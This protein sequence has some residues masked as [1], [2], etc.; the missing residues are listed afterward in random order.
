MN[1]NVTVL[2]DCLAYFDAEQFGHDDNNIDAETAKLMALDQQRLAHMFGED[3]M[4][5]HSVEQYFD[6]DQFNDASVLL[7]T[8]DTLDLVL[9]V[10]S[11]I[12]CDL[13]WEI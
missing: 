8:M 11:S 2:D 7:Q 5:C 13:E 6:A 4:V 3:D 1:D 10:T 12:N 9:L